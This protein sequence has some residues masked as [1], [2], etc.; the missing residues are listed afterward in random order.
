MEEVKLNF[1]PLTLVI[2]KERED[3]YEKMK[4]AVE[5]ANKMLNDAKVDVEFKLEIMRVLAILARVL[6]GAA[7]DIRMEELIAELEGL[8]EK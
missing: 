3:V 8:E 2:P 6:L 4:K 5:S 7:K 1:Q